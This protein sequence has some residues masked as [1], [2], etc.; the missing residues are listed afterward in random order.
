MLDGI[1]FGGT[2]GIVS[3][4]NS[5]AECIA[6]LFLDFGFP[7][8]GS[9]T[10]AAARVRQDQKFGSMAPS[11][12]SFALPPCGDRMG[13][14]GRRIVRDANADRTAVVRRVVNAVGDAYSAGIGEEVVIVY[15]NGRAIPFGSGALEVANH[16]PFLA[17]DADDWQTLPLEAVP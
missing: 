8:P 6:Q 5:E 10:V 1:P 9:A 4:R 3:D 16:F 11:T 2:G 12:R 13:G 15:Q 14:E 7:Y 17:I